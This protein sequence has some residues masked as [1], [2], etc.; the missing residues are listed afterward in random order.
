[1]RVLATSLLALLV[2]GGPAYAQGCTPQMVQQLQARGTPPQIIAQMCAGAG[3]G[4]APAAT[5]CATQLGFCPFR[6]QV[7]VPCFCTGQ[8]GTVQGVS[9]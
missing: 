8:F 4:V 6:G 2:F 9:R 7:N 5:V 1:M 3:P